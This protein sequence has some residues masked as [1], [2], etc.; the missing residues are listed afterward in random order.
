MDIDSYATPDGEELLRVSAGR[1]SRPL[2]ERR[3]LGTQVAAAGAFVLA[4]GLLAVLAPWH[5]SLTPGTALVTLVAYVIVERVKFPVAGGWS[6]PT[7]LVFV[8]MLFVLPTAIVPLFAMVAILLG[9]VPGILRGKTPLTRLPANAA[10][11]WFSLGPAL[12][13]VLAG[14]DRFSWTHWPIYVAAL[15]AQFGFDMV[16]TLARCWIA[17]GIKPRVQAPLLLWVY[18]V[19]A[20]LAPLGLAI[21]ASAVGRPALLLLSLPIVGLFALFA[22]ERQQRLEQTLVL[23]SAYHGTALV[24]GEVIE[25]DDNYTGFHSRE[26]VDLSMALATALGLD[27][28]TRRNVEFTALLHDVGKIHVPKEILN[29]PGSLDDDEWAVMRAHTIE[30]QR[31]LRQVGGALANI[32]TFVRSSHEHFDGAGYPDG[33]AGEAIPIEARVVSICDAYN[34]M[35][36]DRPYR[37]AMTHDDAIA[38]LHRVAGT[39]FDPSLVSVFVRIDVEA[40]ANA[41]PKVKEP[42]IAVPEKKHAPRSTRALASAVRLAHALRIA[43]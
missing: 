29:K 43:S 21:A 7:M 2:S 3:E 22:R 17:E 30:G 12:V 25:A 20:M 26:V 35:T 11:A 4:G 16:A 23:S 19:D 41:E 5:K 31:M 27:A 15:F 34:A 8:P 37:R 42:V 33:L 28:S 39:Q 38:E 24:L 32:G 10:D 13:L 1:R 40:A 36:T 18:S 6:Y 9:S 14:T